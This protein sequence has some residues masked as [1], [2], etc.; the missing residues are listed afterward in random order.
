[1]VS[2]IYLLLYLYYTLSSPPLRMGST[3]F[4]HMLDRLLFRP[5]VR[6]SATFSYRNCP[7]LLNTFSFRQIRE[8][9]HPTWEMGIIG[10]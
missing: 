6:T 1:M 4:F 7:L 5:S 2:Q 10:P 8:P 9:F 3:D